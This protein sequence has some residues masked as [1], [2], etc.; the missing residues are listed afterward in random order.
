MRKPELKVTLIYAE[1]G[2]A[3]E[4]ILQSFLRYLKAMLTCRKN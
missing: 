3:R 2:S 4:L 1:S